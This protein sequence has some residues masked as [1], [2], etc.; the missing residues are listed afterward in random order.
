MLTSRLNVPGSAWILSQWWTKGG[1][2]LSQ[3][4]LNQAFTSAAERIAPVM[5]SPV[6]R[7]QKLQLVTVD[8]PQYLYQHGYR[9]WTTYQPGRRFWP[10]QAIEGGWLLALSVLLIAATVWLVRRRAA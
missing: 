4:A 1:T 6:G 3:P 7:T 2:V 8:I 9:Q 5:H 10:F